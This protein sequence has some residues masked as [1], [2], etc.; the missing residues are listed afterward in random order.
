MDTRD[1]CDRCRTWQRGGENSATSGLV[2]EFA[3]GAGRALCRSC[4]RV[5]YEASDDTTRTRMADQ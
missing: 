5:V 1:R 2:T 4:W 3:D